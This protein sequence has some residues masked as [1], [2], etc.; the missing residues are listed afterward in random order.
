MT[1]LVLLFGLLFTVCGAG[2][3]HLNVSD[4]ESISQAATT[5]TK[6]LY[7]YHNVNS[8]A[9]QFDQP[10]PWFWWLSGAGWT[11]LIDYTVYTNDTTYVSDIQAA[12]AQSLGPSFDFV[13]PQQAGWEANDDQVYWV[14]AALTAMEYDFPALPCVTAANNTIGNCTN[15]W[16]AVAVHAF[17]DFVTRWSIDS[18]TCGGG[19]KWQYNPS[20]SGWYY[21]NAVSNGGFFQTAARLARYSGN[22]TYTLW[23]TNIWNWSVRTGLV[24][25][26]YQVFDGM[27]DAEGANCSSI[28][29]DQWSYN[30]AAY[31]SGAAYMYAATADPTWETITHGL[32]ASANSTFFGGP[33]SNA[34]DVMFEPKCEPSGSCNT[35]QASFKGSLATWMA[36][37]SALVPST[38]LTVKAL[39]DS[40]AVAAA[41]ACS[42]LDSDTCGLRWYEGGFDGNAGFGQT[43]AAL[44]VVQSLLVTTA[45]EMAVLS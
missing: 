10:Q 23:A 27:S 42:G 39:L 37:A 12:L 34:T 11:A 18:E 33:S 4:Q 36:K 41:G 2:A 31:L 16:Y 14:Y 22:Q 38:R 44:E 29:H 5:L 1:G 28:N 3:L 7:G 32:L 17:E 30:V 24:G 35:D 15:S 13:P 21:K 26:G 40:S 43:L 19:L 45:P 9:G 8:T 6:G 20:A 25:D